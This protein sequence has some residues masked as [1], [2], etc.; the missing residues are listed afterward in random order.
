MESHFP[1]AAHTN[2]ELNPNAGSS[3]PHGSNMAAFDYMSS[4]YVPAGSHYDGSAPGHQQPNYASMYAS[5]YDSGAMMAAYSSDHASFTGSV[6]PNT[7]SMLY[8]APPMESG[9]FEPVPMYSDYVQPD[10]MA[11]GGEWGE[12]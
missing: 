10:Y 2:S 1:Y 8:S 3:N 12:F 5:T 9:W 7:G 11:T 6:D 4:L